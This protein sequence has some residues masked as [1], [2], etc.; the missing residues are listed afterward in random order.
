MSTNEKNSYLSK[1]TDQERIDP[2]SVLE[3][4]MI[5]CK[6]YELQDLLDDVQEICLTVDEY[7]FSEGRKRAEVLLYFSKIMKVFEAVEIIV[8][9][10]SLINNKSDI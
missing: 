4:F 6:L 10:R 7:P 9:N 1:L 3:D 8:A 5:D 2:L